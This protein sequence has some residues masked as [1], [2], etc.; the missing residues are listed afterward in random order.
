MMKKRISELEGRSI[1]TSRKKNA[2]RKKNE[3]NKNMTS[4]SCGDI[5]RCNIYVMEM[6]ERKER[7]EQKK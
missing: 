7:T 6:P 2:K 4:K 1:K 5:K 3:K